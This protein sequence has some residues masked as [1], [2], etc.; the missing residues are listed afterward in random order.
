M[1]VTKLFADDADVALLY[2][3][4]HGAEEDGGY[5]RVSVSVLSLLLSDVCFACSVILL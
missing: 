1:A 4:G 3:S 5:A 2:F